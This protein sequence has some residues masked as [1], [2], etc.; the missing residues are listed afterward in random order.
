MLA[1]R[2]CVESAA[3]FGEA[4]VHPGK[5]LIDV[6]SQID[7]V[8]ALGVEARRRGVS[9]IP[10]LGAAVPDFTHI[11]IADPRFKSVVVG[12]GVRL[13]SA[14]GQRLGLSTG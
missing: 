2:G 5:L 8:L 4:V 14:R 1:G 10:H 13:P 11:L 9:E 3:H 12:H 7:E 6:G